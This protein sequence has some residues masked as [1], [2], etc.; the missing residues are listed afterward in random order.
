MIKKTIL[1]FG[2]VFCLV[3][4]QTK[5]P[6]LVFILADDLNKK[7]LSCY[8]SKNVQTP[9][10]DKLAAEGM[11]FDHMFSTTAMCAPLRMQ[12]YTG[13]YPVRS[14][15]YPNHGMVKNDVKSIVQYLKPY[16]YR[17]GISGKWH[18][19]PLSVFAF[20]SVEPNLKKNS[21]LD[22]MTKSDDPFVLF[23][24]SHEPHV[25]WNKGD[26]KAFDPSTLVVPEY[27]VDN[28]ETR[29]ALCKYYAEIVYLDNQVKEVMEALK[30][31]GKEE[32]TMV[33]FASEQG[34]Q[35]PGCKWT[36]YDNGIAAAFIARYP[37]LIKPGT[38]SSAMVN[39]IDV[40]P[41]F[42]DLIGAEIPQ[43]DGKSFLNI[44]K[45]NQDNHSD[46]VFGIHT[47]KG[48]M[49][50]PKD[51]YPIRSVRSDQYL[52]IKNLR[53]HVTFGNA[54]TMTDSE[55]YWQS[56]LRDT[57]TNDNAKFLS[58]RYLNRPAIEFYDVTKDPYQLNNLAD[59]SMYMDVIKEM[60]AVLTSWMQDQGDE[61]GK[62][63]DEFHLHKPKKKKKK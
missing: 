25:K 43:M 17:C 31:S 35:L 59:S 22:Y 16:N 58:Q 3:G 48:A 60:D 5:S 9:N 14:G 62:T 47:Q 12:L 13:L 29:A 18:C 55:K 10:I 11:Q 50:S 49:G 8:G 40:L 7:D 57:L 1:L 4:C 61:G 24:C 33:M 54:V 42:M 32:N 44:L 56:W 19:K 20:D 15:A 41:T 2:M 23:V 53:P 26:A 36:L 39:Y 27:L 46:Y 34:A 6:N 21:Y 45:G 37:K 52:Y 38:R 28:E 63:E 30:E 51:G